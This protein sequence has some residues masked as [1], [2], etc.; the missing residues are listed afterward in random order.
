M[1]EF[2][3]L[4][5]MGK[6]IIKTIVISLIVFTFAF[7][8]A[9]DARKKK[10]KTKSKYK[11]IKVIDGG[12][13][14][15]NALYTGKTV[16][17]DEI[18]SLTS[19]QE[20]CGNT[21]PAGKFLING[22]R[23]IKNVVVYLADIKAGKEIPNAPLVIDNVLCAFEPHVSITYRGNMAIN[24]NTDPVLHN[25]HGYINDR[26]VYNIAVPEKGLQVERKLIY[27]GLMTVKCNPH[28]WMVS[29]VHIFTHPYAALTNEKGEFSISDI[30]AGS[31]EVRAWH[32]G[33]GEI[34]L[35]KVNVKA[36]KATIVNAE[37][38]KYP[39]KPKKASPQIRKKP[40]TQDILLE[41]W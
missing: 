39:E 40:K 26:T 36:G 33:L 23:E 38:S 2:I 31:Y 27:S 3:E 17:K 29:Y 22:R 13:V 5:N 15:G 25:F 16:P 32:E 18:I 6:Y 4:Q 7:S 19:Q 8:T 14:S 20:L 37:F 21:L 41:N 28:P 9:V 24:K 35:G 34:S 1:S 11:V 12:S 30:P 10:V